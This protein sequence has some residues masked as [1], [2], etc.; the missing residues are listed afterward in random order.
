MK[1]TAAPPDRGQ[2]ARLDPP[3]LEHL[4]ELYKK[5]QSFL[6]LPSLEQALGTLNW[7]AAAEV[8]M[9]VSI[10]QDEDAKN[11]DRIVAGKEIRRL[12]M[13]ALR[14]SGHLTELTGRVE[15][16]PDGSVTRTVSMSGVVGNMKTGD[17]LLQLSQQEPRT[18]RRLD[19][20][21]NSDDDDDQNTFDYLDLYESDN[22]DESDDEPQTLEEE[23]E[24]Q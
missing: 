20:P 24:L 16:S 9:L 3:D 5:V 8:E 2:L 14:M 18:S 22:S 1:S 15:E 7:D 13:D 23:G 17:M 10:A 12:L 6:D 4:P 21:D 11:R 19:S